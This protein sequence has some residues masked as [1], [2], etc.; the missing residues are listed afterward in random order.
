MTRS[1]T[2]TLTQLTWQ[3]LWALIAADPSFTDTTFS[4]AP[5]VPSK[6]CELEIRNQT[7][8][9]ILQRSN[10]SKQE[11]GYQIFGNTSDT[12]RSALNN[13]DIKEIYLLPDTNPTSVF[14]G[15]VSF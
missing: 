9:S 11:A 8:G 5:Y 10:D 13:I 7:A 14:V 6:V 4:N 12:M 2:F 3:N 15:F 1:W